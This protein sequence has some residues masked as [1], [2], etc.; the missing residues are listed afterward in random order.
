MNNKKKFLIIC[1]FIILGSFIGYFVVKEFQTQKTQNVGVF[2]GQI[3]YAQG[4]I[5]FALMF[6]GMPTGIVL[7]RYFVQKYINLGL[8]PKALFIV[9]SFM[10]FPIYT[11]IGVV[12]CI[13]Y[14]IFLLIDF[15]RDS[16]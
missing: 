6:G 16:N 4:M 1:G 11:L 9:I 2:Q 10:L 12:S 7:Y 14:L 3:T 15:Y 13:P 5:S 8:M